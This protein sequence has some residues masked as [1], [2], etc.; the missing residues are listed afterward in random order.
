MTHKDQ[1]CTVLQWY[2]EK[3]RKPSKQTQHQ[4]IDSA[5][6]AQGIFQK[7]MSL[8]A[9]AV[10]LHEHVKQSH[11]SAP[12]SNFFFFNFETTISN[13]CPMSSAL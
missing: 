1:C 5:N 9:V 3:S 13:P 2:L 11:N 7:E 8:Y 12:H 10:Y 4:E 6:E